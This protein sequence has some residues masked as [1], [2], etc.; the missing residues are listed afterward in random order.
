[1]FNKLTNFASFW[2]T[3][4]F[5]SVGSSR[6]QALPKL[7]S[8]EGQKTLK[9]TGGHIVVCLLATWIELRRK[10]SMRPRISGNLTSSFLFQNG[11]TSYYVLL[12]PELNKNGF[13]NNPGSSFQVPQEKTN[14]LVLQL[15]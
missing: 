14:Q 1:M 9:T 15:N 6:I 10:K 5:F 13:R 12:G 2:F 8:P 3:T 7:M 11:W 4:E